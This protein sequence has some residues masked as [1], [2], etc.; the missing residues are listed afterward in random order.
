MAGLEHLDRCGW[1][2][3]GNADYLRAAASEFV[4][5]TNDGSRME[6]ALAVTPTS[7]LHF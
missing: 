1:L 7:L 5:K 4:E 2:K 3:A 6:A